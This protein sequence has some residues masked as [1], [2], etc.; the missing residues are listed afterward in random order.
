MLLFIWI[1]QAAGITHRTPVVPSKKE[2]SPTVDTVELPETLKPDFTIGSRNNKSKRFY[3]N[4]LV[5]P[6]PATFGHP[7]FW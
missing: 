5:G 3:H 4:Q 2:G 6:S 7:G 1:S